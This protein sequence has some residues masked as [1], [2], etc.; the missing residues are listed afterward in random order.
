MALCVVGARYCWSIP[1][2]Y[3]N[4]RFVFV[5]MDYFT[6]WVEAEVLANIRDMDVKKFVWRIIVMKFGVLESLVLDNGLQFDSTTFR[7]FCSS[8]GIE[9]KYFTSA[10]PQSNGQAEAI[11]KAIVNVLKKRLE[12]TKGR[13]EEKLSNILWAYR[14]I[15]RR[16]IGETPFFRT[17]GAE[18]VIPAEINLCS[19]QVLGFTPTKNA[20][21]MLR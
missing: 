12:G 10:Y 2:G 6:K 18:A 5:A 11:N 9:N 8:L 1:S 17:Y 7:K 19:A 20:E 15:L 4:Q 16:S 21:L 3:R 13:W 14:T